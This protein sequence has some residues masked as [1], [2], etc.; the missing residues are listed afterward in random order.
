M[1]CFLFLFVD[2][3]NQDEPVIRAFIRDTIRLYNPSPSGYY[4]LDFN[5]IGDINLEVNST[6][7]ESLTEIEFKKLPVHI[8]SESGPNQI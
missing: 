6:H 7:P 2:R 5:T 1:I 4:Y 3:L 8:K